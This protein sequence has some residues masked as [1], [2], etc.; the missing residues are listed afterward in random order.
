[1][2]EED[3]PS[4][5]GHVEDPEAVTAD[6]SNKD[7]FYAQKVRCIVTCWECYKPSVVYSKG[8]L[9]VQER[10][11]LTEVDDSRVYTCGSTFSPSS[12]FKSTPEHSVYISSQGSVLQRKVSQFPSSHCGG[13]ETLVN[14]EEWT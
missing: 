1:M 14:D 5:R 8:K 9:T 11:A 6:L 10:N 4:V 2:S 13:S 7:L 3:R 12:D